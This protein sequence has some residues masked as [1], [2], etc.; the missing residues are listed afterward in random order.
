MLMDCF[1]SSKSAHVFLTNEFGD[2]NLDLRRKG[3]VFVC[4]S[5]VSRKILETRP[6]LIHSLDLIL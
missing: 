4:C 1:R 5:L 6:R 3:Y 2:G